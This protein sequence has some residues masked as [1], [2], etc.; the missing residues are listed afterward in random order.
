[1]EGLVGYSRRHFTVPLPVAD[2]FDALN[3]TL[4]DGCVQRQQAV[5]RGD[6]GSI[7]QRLVLDRVALMPLPAVPY[8]ARHKQSCRV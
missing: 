4:L 1:M 7:A 8:D 3:A 6:T 2:D 5:S